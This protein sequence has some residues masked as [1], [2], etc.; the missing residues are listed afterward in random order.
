M[1][2]HPP[3]QLLLIVR[4]KHGIHGASAEMYTAQDR[5]NQDWLIR[6]LQS[7]IRLPL[8]NGEFLP[9]AHGIDAPITRGRYL[10]TV[11]TRNQTISEQLD[12]A[13]CSNGLWSEAI[14]LSGPGRKENKIFKGLP[15]C[16]EPFAP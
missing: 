3:F 7:K 2:E 4:G 9:G 6:Q 16:H 14:R 11:I 13:Q 12:I 10:V 8:G 5:Q 1:S 15:G